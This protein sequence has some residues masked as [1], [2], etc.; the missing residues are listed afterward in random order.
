M[1]DITKYHGMRH[2]HRVQRQMSKSTLNAEKMTQE[3]GLLA[4]MGHA[5]ANLRD[6][7]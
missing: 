2:R 5:S 3:Q 1:K 4:P 7:R 6:E